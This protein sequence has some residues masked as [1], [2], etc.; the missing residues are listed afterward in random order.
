MTK[1]DSFESDNIETTKK[2]AYKFADRFLKGKDRVVV[3]LKG[4]LG[5]GKTTFVRFILESFGIGES[6]FDGSPSFTIINSY[7]NIHHIDLYRIDE[8]FVY[9]T[10]IFEMI[11]SGG[12]FLIE[13][14]KGGIEAD[15]IV[16]FTQIDENRRRIDV[17]YS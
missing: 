15:I 9:E 8:D 6:E 16:E 11:E 17:Y 14:P 7:G 4:D 12:I 2:I 10:G 3:F 13:W 5:S 1:K